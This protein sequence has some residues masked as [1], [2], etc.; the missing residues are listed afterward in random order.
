MEES[1]IGLST[2]DEEEE[3]IQLGVE[4]SDQETSFAN[5]FV[6]MFLTSSVVNFQAMR[7]TLENEGE[8]PMI[9]QLYWVDFWVLTYDPLHGFMSEAVANLRTLLSASRVS[10]TVDSNE[11]F[12][13]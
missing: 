4:S 1:I 10:M 9:V 6:G 2:E 7:T 3:I 11:A 12:G 13:N 5:C 8:D